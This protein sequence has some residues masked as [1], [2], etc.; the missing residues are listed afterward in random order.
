VLR[1]LRSLP[2]SPRDR[3]FWRLVERYRDQI[4]DETYGYVVG[5]VAASALAAE[6]AAFGLA[7]LARAP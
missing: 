4:P 6:P 7:R 3:N 1:L 5:I 2:A